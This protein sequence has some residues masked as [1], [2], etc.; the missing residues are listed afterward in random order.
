MGRKWRRWSRCRNSNFRH[1]EV[2]V[3][4][5]SSSQWSCLEALVKDIVYVN[6]SLTIVCSS[7]II[8][9]SFI[10]CVRWPPVASPVYQQ[11][12]DFL[13]I[14]DTTETFSMCSYVNC[15]N[16]KSNQKIVFPQ[17]HLLKILNV[18]QE[19]E[20][21]LNHN[22]NPTMIQTLD[23]I[24]LVTCNL[25]CLYLCK[26]VILSCYFILTKPHSEGEYLL[27]S[28]ILTFTN[29][30]TTPPP[31]LFVSQIFNVSSTKRRCS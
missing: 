10:D 1:S 28:H 12:D 8:M 29:T 3:L 18:T 31:S 4:V 23:M 19:W 2:L 7:L 26:N 6:T 11:E 17:P 5:V 24:P 22:S 15:K 16:S 9:K 25:T 14:T 30:T 20:F 13:P 21:N 27:S